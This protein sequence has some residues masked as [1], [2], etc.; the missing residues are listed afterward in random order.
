MEYVDDLF[1]FTFAHEAMVYMH[2]DELLSETDELLSALLLEF[3]SAV[4]VLSP[5]AVIQAAAITIDKTAARTFFFINIA[6][7]GF[8]YVYH[9]TAYNICQGSH[10]K[11]PC[12]RHSPLKI[13][14]TR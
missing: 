6:P 11:E 7:F 4:L 5:Q 13:S 3:A 14:I 2:A 9:I 1:G 8:T 12:T 10:K